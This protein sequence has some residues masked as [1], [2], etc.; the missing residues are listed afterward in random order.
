MKATTYEVRVTVEVINHNV[1][2]HRQGHFVKR[3]EMAIATFGDG[4]PNRVDRDQ[5]LA[6]A[7]AITASIQAANY[8]AKVYG[9]DSTSKVALVKVK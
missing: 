5:A 4:K 1:K 9:A 6:F 3:K 8:A 2:T 7:S